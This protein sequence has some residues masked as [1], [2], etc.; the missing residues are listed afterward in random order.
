MLA[1]SRTT[2]LAK[3]FGELMLHSSGASTSPTR[4]HRRRKNSYI[5]SLKLSRDLSTVMGNL[6]VVLR[7]ARFPLTPD[8]ACSYT[9]EN[10]TEFDA[11]VTHV[12]RRI[13]VRN[14]T[15]FSQTGLLPN[16]IWRVP[17]RGSSVLESEVSPWINLWCWK[18]W[19]VLYV[20]SRPHRYRSC[21]TTL[22]T[23]TC[24]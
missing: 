8:K 13:N 19:Y 18:H 20:G 3:I 1:F 11:C 14:V 24:Q 2:K 5:L 12:A 16:A 7:G 23:C 22:Y 17:L 15:A 10:R 4:L 9:C 21:I 6:F